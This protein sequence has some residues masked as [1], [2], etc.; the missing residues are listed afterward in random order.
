M[1]NMLE[2]IQNNFHAAVFII[3]GFNGVMSYGAILN[4]Y[5]YEGNKCDPH[6]LRC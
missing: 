3:L 1:F 4:I 2:K 6:F 5:L